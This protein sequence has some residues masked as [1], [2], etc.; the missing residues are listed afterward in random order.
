MFGL[1]WAIA[2]AEKIAGLVLAR[3]IS[4]SPK[5]RVGKAFDGA[6]CILSVGKKIG[7]IILVSFREAGYTPKAVGG[8]WSILSAGEHWQQVKAAW[9]LSRGFQYPF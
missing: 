8:V 3:S 7:E 5:S 6:W 1:L 4:C 9:Q 2:V